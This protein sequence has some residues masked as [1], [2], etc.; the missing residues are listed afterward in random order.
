MRARF[1]L[2]H[3]A[4]VAVDRRV[5]AAI[6]YYV[7]AAANDSHILAITA[8][9]ITARRSCVV[10]NAAKRAHVDGIDSSSSRSSTGAATRRHQG[11]RLLGG[12]H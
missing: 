3:H 8:G 11:A 12:R 5:A 2:Y 1:T 10:I 7:T 4:A 9:A 6:H